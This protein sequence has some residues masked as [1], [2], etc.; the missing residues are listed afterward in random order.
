MDAR[1][2]KNWDEVCKIANLDITDVWYG[3]TCNSLWCLES[4][5]NLKDFYVGWDSWSCNFFHVSLL[6]FSKPS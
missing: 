3:P 4:L 2:G 1:N 6:N 5:K